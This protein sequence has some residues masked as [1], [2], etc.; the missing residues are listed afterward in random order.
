MPYF[1]CQNQECV[2]Y[3][4]KYRVSDMTARIYILKCKKCKQEVKRVSSLL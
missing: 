3:K 2:E 1:T 4:K